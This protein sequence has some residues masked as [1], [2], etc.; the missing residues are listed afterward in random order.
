MPLTDA[1]LIEL[2][3]R[4]AAALDEEG[5]FLV[6]VDIDDWGVQR[7]SIPVSDRPFF[8]AVTE[9]AA[10]LRDL[11]ELVRARQRG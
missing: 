11:V 3:N 10:A 1:A 7:P 6:D 4:A 5:A 9:Q 2:L 8:E